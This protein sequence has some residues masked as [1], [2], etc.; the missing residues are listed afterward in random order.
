MSSEFSALPPLPPSPDLAAYSTDRPA[1]SKLTSVADQPVLTF[2]PLSC[3]CGPGG[4]WPAGRRSPQDDC[5]E[6]AERVDLAQVGSLHARIELMASRCRIVAKLTRACARTG[7]SFDERIRLG[8]Q[9]LLL[10]SR[11]SP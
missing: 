8:E 9:G 3:V 2:S 5:S 6:A 7:L 4:V 1:S 11:G 10:A